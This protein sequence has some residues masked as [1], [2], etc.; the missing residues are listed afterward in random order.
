MTRPSPRA[1]QV[2]S[3]PLLHRGDCQERFHVV[4][5]GL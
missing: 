5:I 1:Q 4:G 2:L 3:T